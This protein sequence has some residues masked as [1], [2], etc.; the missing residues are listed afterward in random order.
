MNILERINYEGL[1]E[2]KTLSKLSLKSAKMPPK[3]EL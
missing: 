2:T 3:D 1:V